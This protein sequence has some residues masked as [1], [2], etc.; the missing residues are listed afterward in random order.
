MSLVG[1]EDL[2][3]KVLE[4][5]VVNNPDL[6]RL[7]ALLDR[8]NIFEAVGLVWQEVRHSTFLA[9]LLDPRASHGLGDAF[10][11]RLLQRAVMASPNVSHP[12]TPTE[13]SLC[14]LGQMEVRREWRRIDIFLCDERE[15]LT[16]VIENKIGSGEHGDQL[17][18]SVGEKEDLGC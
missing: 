11:K 17:D 4:A 8:F 12:V 7:E 13:L 3:R 9:F 16:V 2:D 18:R 6:E 1:S 5:F 15:K 14:D 10:A